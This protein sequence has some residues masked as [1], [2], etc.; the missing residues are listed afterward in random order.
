MEGSVCR[1]ESLGFGAAFE[2][3]WSKQLQVA[4]GLSFELAMLGRFKAQ[5]EV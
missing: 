5:Q 1:S 4:M 3:C 2:M